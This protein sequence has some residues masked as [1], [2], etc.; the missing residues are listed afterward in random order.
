[1]KISW[2]SLKVSITGAR[3]SHLVQTDSIWDHGTMIEHIKTVF[4]QVQKAKMKGEADGLKKYMT[5]AGY[6]KLKKQ[7]NELPL[8]GKKEIKNYKI[9][10]VAVIDVM[11]ATNKHADFFTALLK[12][13]ETTDIADLNN[14][15]QVLQHDDIT[16]EFSEQ[17]VFVRQGDW[18]MLDEMKTKK[19]I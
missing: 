8:T 11:P 16:H 3:L 4:F 6:E 5:L 15:G 13:Y 14:S 2:N 12:G 18:W 17:W 10:E 9:K 1:M 19:H 7:M